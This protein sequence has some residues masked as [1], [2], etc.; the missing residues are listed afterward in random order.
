LAS[1]DPLISSIE[2]VPF[3]AAQVE[4]LADCLFAWWSR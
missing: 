3:A 2:G 4:V 1:V